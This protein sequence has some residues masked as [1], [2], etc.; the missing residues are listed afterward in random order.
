MAIMT[1]A[2]TAMHLNF[3]A[4]KHLSRTR[5]MAPLILM[6]D[7]DRLPNPISVLENLPAG[8]GVI[9]RPGA[10]NLDQGSVALGQKIRDA[11]RQR[12]LRFIVSGPAQFALRLQADGQHI[13]QWQMKKGG[14]MIRPRKR[15]IITAS[16][17]DVA[18]LIAASRAGADIALL[19]PVFKT[20][21]HPGA[22][23]LG[24]LKFS[25]LAQASPIPVYA[26]GGI[27][28]NTARR[29]KGADACGIA[30]IGA[31]AQ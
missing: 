29:L 4:R 13:P 3:Q 22:R 28:A 16:C 26:L 10:T 17:H 27:D 2:K 14:R 15:W 8:A 12:G 9:Y 7:P 6:T 20:K 23:T 24:S 18:S 25:A 30:G 5:S 11:C 19:S 21:S 31:L 1:I